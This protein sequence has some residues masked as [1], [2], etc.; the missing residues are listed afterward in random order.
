MNTF[1]KINNI[2][3]WI[4]WAI[5]SVV[6]LMTMEST[7]SLW[8][9][10]EF[11][12]SAHKLEIGHPP[13]A[14]IFMLMG[15]FFTLFAPDVS[16]VAIMANSL[17]ALVSSFTILFLFW[18][19]THFARKL[20]IK[21]EE[22]D[23]NTTNFIL[24]MGAGLVGALTFTFT[25]SF[26]FSAV[27][28]EVYAASAF[29]T[30]LTFWCI[31]KWENVKDSPFSSRWLILIAYLIGLS[32]GVHLLNLLIIPAVTMIYFFN[33]YEIT[34]KKTAIAA[35]ISIGILGVIQGGIIPWLPL[36]ASR[37]ELV[38][39]NTM[40]LPF[41]SGLLFFMVLLFSGLAYGLYYT[42]KHKKVLM[43]H[44]LLFLTFIIMAYSSF[45]LIMIRSMANPPMDQNNPEN[46]FSL[47]SYLTREQYGDRP[48]LY[49]YYFNVANIMPTSYED[50]RAN[51]AAL[52][53]K[54]VVTHHN[55]EIEYPDEFA[56]VFP[57]MHS[58]RNDHI[59]AYNNIVDIK[60]KPVRARARNGEEVVE[61]VPTMGEN[62]NFFFRYQIY[63]MY[64]RYFMWNFSGRQNDN[65]GFYGDIINGNW[66][67]GIPFLDKKIAGYNDKLPEHFKNDPTRNKYY[68]L[69]F[70][71]GIIGLYYH[72]K[73]SKKDFSVLFLLFFM[74]GLAII[75]Y[76]NQPPIEPRERDYTYV[77][78]FLRLRNMDW[79]GC[80]CY[81]RMDATI[82]IQKS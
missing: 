63:H 41:H 80:S 51:Y 49:G 45:A 18:T 54:Y 25:D 2:S 64:F 5:A 20:V 21:N 60:G 13:G 7:V 73:K 48:L 10:G 74:T 30:A 14:P 52:D 72:I 17:S 32:I 11:I 39:V 42:H 6:Y 81:R 56:S 58:Y 76:L 62:L 77:G 78:S 59:R 66:I 53:G 61:R 69:P 27:E 28:G 75:T 50:G 47:N 1:R 22:T 16:Y 19:I 3:G 67:T 24:I 31:I 34:P 57:R 40:G 33:K 70:I 4:V 15:R 38:A 23:F 9:C 12:A 68:M 55:P 8:D 26:W 44:I 46:I 43:N 37:F 65:Q 36:I 82:F 29:F 71:L 79:S 35:I